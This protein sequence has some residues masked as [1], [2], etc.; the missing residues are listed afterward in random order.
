MWY[1]NIQIEVYVAILLFLCI[2]IK[3]SV[4]CVLF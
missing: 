1:N 2:V 4:F 3:G